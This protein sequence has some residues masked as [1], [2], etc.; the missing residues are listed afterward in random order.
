MPADY[1]FRK[2]SDPRSEAFF[3]KA[4]A[5]YAPVVL[6]GF[7]SGTN[8]G[9]ST[10]MHRNLL[11]ISGITAEPRRYD[12]RPGYVHWDDY[13]ETMVDTILQMADAGDFGRHVSGQHVDPP[14]TISVQAAIVGGPAPD[15]EREVSILLQDPAETISLSG[16]VGSLPALTAPAARRAQAPVR[17]R[18]AQAVIDTRTQ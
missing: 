15:L 12:N 14:E 13:A 8:I 6:R 17:S 18:R 5:H 7:E 11:G 10:V 4:A 2:S 9:V 1:I 16:L 3:D